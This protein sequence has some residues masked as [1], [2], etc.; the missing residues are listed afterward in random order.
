MELQIACCD[1]EILSGRMF[2]DKIKAEF[3]RQGIEASVTLINQPK[4]FLAMLE[5]GCPFDACFLDV[6]M[7]E[8]DGITLGKRLIELAPDTGIVFLSNKEEMVYR[9]FQ[10]KPLRFL[11]KSKFDLEISDAVRAILTS[12]KEKEQKTVIFE[13]G[14]T[15]YRFF[16]REIIYVE[17]INRTLTV[18]RA[19]DSV[20]FRATIAAAEEMLAP[21]G[22]LRI[23]KSFL[24]N[25]RTVFSIQKDGVQLENGKVL[26]ISKHRYREVLQQFLYFHR[27]EVEKAGK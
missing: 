18:V 5:A 12:I 1:D 23:H 4:R 2:A 3:R 10:V 20:S 11:R 16:P 19:K 15:I 8:L 13:D 25:Y 17:I 27:K 14:N 7:P 26:P 21:H 6:D 22:F 9:S 24:V